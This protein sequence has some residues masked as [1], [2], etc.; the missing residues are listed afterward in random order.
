MSHKIGGNIEHTNNL[1][2]PC[3]KV[4]SFLVVN[5]APNSIAGPKTSIECVWLPFELLANLSVVA[6]VAYRP[7]VQ[8]DLIIG[9]VAELSAEPDRYDRATGVEVV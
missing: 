9:I 5:S 2:A 6:V 7:E 3:E 8:A 1:S 4:R